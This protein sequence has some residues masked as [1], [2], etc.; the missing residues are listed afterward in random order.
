MI[1]AEQIS[2]ICQ[3][4]NDQ[5]EIRQQNVGS[6]W[7]LCGKLG[8]LKI[9]PLGTCRFHSTSGAVSDTTEIKSELELMMFLQELIRG[10]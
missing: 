7:V 5:F 6:I 10:I 3:S 8:T 1:D 4:F 9:H 2:V